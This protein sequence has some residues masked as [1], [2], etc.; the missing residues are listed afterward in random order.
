MP[1]KE[2]EQDE[3]VNVPVEEGRESRPESMLGLGLRRV[4]S[5]LNTSR[6]WG[7]A[8]EVKKAG[9]IRIGFVF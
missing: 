1:F 2:P 4:V 9:S 6:Y 7:A 3:E 8:E 5:C